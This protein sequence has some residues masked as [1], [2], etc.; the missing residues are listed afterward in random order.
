MARMQQVGGAMDGKKQRR[1]TGKKHKQE[2]KKKKGG[3]ED[4][5]HISLKG[6]H[7]EVVKHHKGCGEKNHN[8]LKRFSREREV[9]MVPLYISCSFVF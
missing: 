6:T 3:K 8:G 2:E 9:V 4:E 5:G 1:L 7:Q